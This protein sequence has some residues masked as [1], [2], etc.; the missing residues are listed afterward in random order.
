[1]PTVQ[2]IADKIDRKYP[3]AATDAQVVDLI[4]TW[5]KRI[6]RK[7]RIPT[8]AEYEILADTFAYNLGIKPRL[9]FDV[10]VDGIS[11][12]KKSLVG[13]ST[14]DSNYYT[15]IDNYIRI[16]PTPTEDGTLTVYYYD[17]PATLSS[18]SMG[19]TPDLDEDFHD[20]L[21]YGPCKELAEDDQ[22]YDVAT[23]FAIQYTDL[24]TELAE[25][26]QIL[27]EPETV[28]MESGW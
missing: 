25:V 20:L 6:F 22:R 23:G 27:P 12:A 17:T 16:Y 14:S 18:S 9:I 8:S 10:L 28:Q 11:Y 3:N 26:F 4:D 21:V 13:R 19:T 1:M 24:E 2:E 15:F 7:Y 5:Q